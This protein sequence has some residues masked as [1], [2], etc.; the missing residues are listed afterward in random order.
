MDPY[1]FYSGFSDR[2]YERFLSDNGLEIESLTPVGD[3]YSWMAVE[4]ARTAASH[5]IM[6]KLILAPAFL[7]F[8]NK[9]KTQLS[10]DT[11][12]MGYHVVARKTS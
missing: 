5:S 8:Y 4:M 7:Y 3:Y 10:I 9:K 11:L 6:S 2:W 12:C 1:F